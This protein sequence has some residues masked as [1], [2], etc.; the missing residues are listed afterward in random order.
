MLV[1]VLR[2]RRTT[3]L[4]SK[5]SQEADQVGGLCETPWDEPRLALR[6][7][8]TPEVLDDRLRVHGR[9]RV[10]LELA[11]RR[12]A[13]QAFSGRAEL[14]EDLLVRVALADPSLELGQGLGID[15]REGRPLGRAFP[16]HGKKNRSEWS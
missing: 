10:L 2:G 9:G 12:R 8:P 16:G 15:A 13:P 6:V 1:E 11:H 7:V 14:V 5:L 4:V 3:E